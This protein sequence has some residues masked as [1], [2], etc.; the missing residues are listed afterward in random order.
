MNQLFKSAP[1]GV[2]EWMITL[3]S[4]ALV[5]FVIECEKVLYLKRRNIH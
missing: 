3:G 5:Y 4:S 2:L 1:L